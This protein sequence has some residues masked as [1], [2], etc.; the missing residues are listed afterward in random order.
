MGRRTAEWFAYADAYGHDVKPVTL[1]A[2]ITDETELTEIVVH[3]ERACRVPKDIADELHRL[4]A[5]W[6]NALKLI[7]GS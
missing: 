1:A 3:G 4:R 2:R 5:G 6:A 7:P